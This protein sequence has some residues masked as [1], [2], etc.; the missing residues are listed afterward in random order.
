MQ[1]E[2]VSETELPTSFQNFNVWF[3]KCPRRT[4]RGLL[5]SILL[6]SNDFHV[7]H[8]EQQPDFQLFKN[9]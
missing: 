1:K 2:V 7:P 5:L 8:N 4:R 3:L 9:N 6:V